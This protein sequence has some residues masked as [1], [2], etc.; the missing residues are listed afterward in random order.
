MSDKLLAVV[1]IPRSGSTAVYEAIRVE[2]KLQG[3][4]EPGNPIM[5]QYQSEAIRDI[6]EPLVH[7]RKRQADGLVKYLV[8]HGIELV[9][10][11]LAEA[12]YT[13]LKMSGFPSLVG[14]ELVRKVVVTYRENVFRQALSMCIACKTGFWH[15]NPS[16]FHC[17]DIGKLHAPLFG[18]TL[19]LFRAQN[20]F[21]LDVASHNLNKDKLITCKYEDFFEG[22]CDQSA[23]WERLFQ[24]LG[25]DYD[26]SLLERI[27][28]KRYN[29][30]HT[31]SCVD[32][33]SELEDVYAEFTSSDK[34]CS[35]LL[36]EL[37]SK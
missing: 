21:L 18:Q 14:C 29:S 8:N 2:G 16:E 31:Y 5:A 13:T 4:C 23:H 20:N 25:Y 9:K 24:F 33:L 30:P 35:D 28:S 36:E 10:L 15:G 32:N 34:S 27:N 6:C 1:G 26:S 3:V 12:S 22:G 17:T 19:S 7:G 37:P 11:M